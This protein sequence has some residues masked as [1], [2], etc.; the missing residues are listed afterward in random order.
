MNDSKLMT[1]LR[2]AATGLAYL[3]SE[4]I[5]HKSVRPSNILVSARLTL[6]STNKQ[7]VLII[8]SANFFPNHG[9]SLHS[10]PIL[11]LTFHV[12]EVRVLGLESWDLFWVS[13]SSWWVLEP[14]VPG[15]LGFLGRGLFI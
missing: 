7:R 1:Y 3:H 14:V 2:D 8:G 12:I 6:L 10:I 11:S 15:L 5:V 13:V 4:N 9:Y